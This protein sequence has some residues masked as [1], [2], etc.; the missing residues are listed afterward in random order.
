MKRKRKIPSLI[1]GGIGVLFLC[2]GIY[3]EVFVKNMFNNQELN[4]AVGIIGGADGPTSI[5]IAG[6]L[7]TNLVPWILGI[8]IVLIIICVVRLL[9]KRK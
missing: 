6:R 9:K 1:I 8:G 2:I 4:A 5:F 7:D 3:I